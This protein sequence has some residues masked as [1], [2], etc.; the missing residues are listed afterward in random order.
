L[1]DQIADDLWSQTHAPGGGA[2]HGPEQ[3]LGRTCLEYVSACA[4][5]QRAYDVDAPGR[6]PL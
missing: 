3:F 4:G 5:L 1:T 2:A 6:R